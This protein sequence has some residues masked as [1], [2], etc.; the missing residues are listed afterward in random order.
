MSALHDLIQSYARGAVSRRGFLARASA[1]GVSS[2]LA[3]VIAGQPRAFAQDATPV[4]PPVEE[5]TAV[6]VE[7]MPVDSIAAVETPQPDVVAPTEPLDTVA[8][9]T[10]EPTLP[11]PTATPAPT[12]EPTPTPTPAP[13]NI[14]IAAESGTQ[15]FDITC[16]PVSPAGPI[17]RSHTATTRCLL[18]SRDGANPRN[19]SV[20]ATIRATTPAGDS[21]LR[22][23]GMQACAGEPSA[24]CLNSP[25]PAQLRQGVSFTLTIQPPCTW[26]GTDGAYTASVTGSFVGT[27]GAAGPIADSTAV[28]PF[29]ILGYSG[30][31]P[32][33]AL[34]SPSVDFGATQWTGN[35][36]A[37][38]AGALSLTINQPTGT[39]PPPSTIFLSGSPL[40]S[41]S[42]VIPTDAVQMSSVLTRRSV[43][44]GNAQ[45]APGPLDQPRVIFTTT[46][47][48][49]PG[50]PEGK[51]EILLDLMPPPTAPPGAYRGTVV[52]TTTAPTP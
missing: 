26:T 10:P 23:E 41:D 48:V 31:P 17:R 39:C 38:L 33:V 14:G 12:P 28:V 25:T 42:S 4:V 43:P 9:V 22:L 32:I 18:K 29:Q 20:R 36:Y 16:D 15:V 7:E 34:D 51:V 5:P 1:L 13:R 6:P 30:T 8:T 35:G 21:I 3:G 46:T 24:I 19:L 2:A 47:P 11:A 37:P 50:A 27:T 44:W 52:I 49:A 45:G 40:A